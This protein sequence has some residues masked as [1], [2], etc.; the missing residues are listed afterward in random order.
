MRSVTN[1]RAPTEGMKPSTRGSG[2]A[3]NGAVTPN[4]T[5]VAVMTLTAK[6]RSLD[7]GGK[8]CDALLGPRCGCNEHKKQCAHETQEGP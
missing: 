7:V 3:A 6:R 2:V 1:I 4:A 8:V 5:N